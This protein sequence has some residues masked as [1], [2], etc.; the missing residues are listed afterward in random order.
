MRA[1]FLNPADVEEVLT[2]VFE[3]ASREGVEVALAGG[4]AMELLGSD[5]L[6]KDVDFVCSAVLPSIRAVKPLSFGGISGL[7]RNGHPVDLIVRDDEYAELYQEALANALSS[8]DVVVKVVAPEY[9]AAMKMAAGRDKDEMDLKTLIRLGTI[10]LP[11][12]E[13]VIRRHLGRY[14]VKEFKSLVAEVDWLSK[15]RTER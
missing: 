15:Q 14:A 5:R 9:L 8:P 12:T 11:K 3:D 7:S 13:D 2:D 1:K 10:S 6:T 4:V